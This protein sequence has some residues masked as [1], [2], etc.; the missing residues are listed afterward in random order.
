MARTRTRLAYTDPDWQS[1]IRAMFSYTLMNRNQF[2]ISAHTNTSVWV[3]LLVISHAAKFNEPYLT[4]MNIQTDVFHIIMLNVS[5]VCIESV[6]VC[7]HI[8]IE[9]I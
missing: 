2:F 5:C 7:S 6:R 3:V 1:G 4:N 8:P 9:I